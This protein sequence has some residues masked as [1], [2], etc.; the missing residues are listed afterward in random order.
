M[1]CCSARALIIA[2]DYCASPCRQTALCL[3]ACLCYYRAIRCGQPAAQTVFPISR[4]AQTLA[5][6]RSSG[7]RVYCLHK[8]TAKRAV[9]AEGNL[10]LR[11]PCLPLS[12]ESK[13]PAMQVVIDFQRIFIMGRKRSTAPPARKTSPRATV[14]A[15]APPSRLAPPARAWTFFGI[16]LFAFLLYANTLG[17]GYV[18]DDDHV[19]VENRIVRQGLAAIPEIFSTSY[20]QGCPGM[21]PDGLYRPLSLVMFAAEWQ[22]FPGRPVVGHLI[23]VLLYGLTG[24]MLFMVLLQWTRRDARAY[25]LALA[26]TLLFL[27][28]PVHTE[29][30]ANIKSRDEILSLLLML[31]CL[32]LQQRSLLAGSR[33]QQLLG[34]VAA[35]LA[36]LS[37]E[38]AIALIVL[39]PLALY[40][41]TDART[42]RIVRTG[43]CLCAVAGAY[44]AIRWMVMGIDTF[45]ISR[46]TLLDNSLV[47]APVWSLR[48]ATALLILGKYLGLLVLPV[49]L[50]WDYSYPAIPLVSWSSPLALASCAAYCAIAAA[51]CL[52]LKKKLLPGLAVFFY[53]ACLAPAANI[54]VLIGS[55][56]AERLL[57][58]PSVGFCLLVSCILVRACARG[59]ERGQGQTLVKAV[60]ANRV[61]CVVLLCII[62]LYGGR[63]VVRNAD[64]T[65]SLTLYDHDRAGSLSAR[66]QYT[67]GR[68]VLK[69]YGETLK[70]GEAPAAC[71]DSAVQALQD[72]VR[73]YPRYGD[74]YM[75][76]GT[77][78]AYKNE[79]VKAIEQ[80]NLALKYSPDNAEIYDNLA[81]AWGMTGDI[82]KA[83]GYCLR[84]LSYAPG[85][86]DIYNNLG[87]LYGMAGDMDKAIASFQKA[88]ALGPLRNA[89]YN[90]ALA[91]QQKKQ[92]ALAA[93]ELH[94]LLSRWPGDEPARRLQESIAA[95][96]K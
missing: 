9:D 67:Y 42:G 74:A 14:L 21:G 50:S 68:E 23:N 90:L 6:R 19:I 18:A 12:G 83:V 46:L 61:L 87:T 82:E 13:P 40:F 51:G 86:P 95:A 72:A 54:F 17:S 65:S 80:Y 22:F 37:K 44:F 85:N 52:C 39:C 93:A 31:C 53:L 56:M 57:Y 78:H 89:Y 36:L 92:N 84:G 20:R 69:L 5:R 71:L 10:A 28:H 70:S 63:T 27:A 96:R 24:I 94:K 1:A 16:A 41:F 47:A 25:T 75:N 79:P 91:Y 55:T 32:Y 66:T 59:P 33:G 4:A 7:P 29:V 34:L 76:L 62:A 88:I 30:V 77:A 81:T 49:R 3:R 26:A 64:W 73:L 2:H 15:C 38:S 58:A 43:L 48:L 35:F 11:A 8:T 45:Q 60:A